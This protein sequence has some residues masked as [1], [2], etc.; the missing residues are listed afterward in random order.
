M[1]LIADIKHTVNV[2]DKTYTEDVYGTRTVTGSSVYT[3]DAYITFLTSDDEAVK[4]GV[5][6]IG[7]ARGYFAAPGS[8]LKPGQI[9]EFR[10][11]QFEV[12]GEPFVGDIGG[13]VVHYEVNLKR[14]HK[15]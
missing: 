4:S 8:V 13:T 7:D 2:V 10:N 15:P 11:R 1:A 9:V 14:L 6:N 3:P 12:V 5:L